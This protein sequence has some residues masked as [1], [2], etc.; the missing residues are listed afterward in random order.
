ML[1]RIGPK[2]L[3]GLTLHQAF[4]HSLRGEKRRSEDTGRCHGSGVEMDLNIE[5]TGF[6]KS[7]SL[8]DP[9]VQEPNIV[10]MWR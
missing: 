5:D 4:K 6:S 2:E 1:E 9:Y 10:C 7:A 3:D 8:V